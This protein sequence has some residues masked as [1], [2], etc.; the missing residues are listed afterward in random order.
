MWA[1]SR[2]GTVPPKTEELLRGLKMEKGQ[3]SKELRPPL[4]AK[5]RE[6]PGGPSPAD[7]TILAPGGSWR[8]SSLQNHGEYTCVLLT[9]CVLAI[10]HSSS[11]KPIHLCQTA[12]QPSATT[13]KMLLC[14]S[15]FRSLPVQDANGPERQASR[16]TQARGQAVPGCSQTRVPTGAHGGRVAGWQPAVL[17]ARPAPR[18]SPPR[19]ERRGELGPPQVGRLPGC[20]GLQ[21]VPVD[22]AGPE[23]LPADPPGPPSVLHRDQPSIPPRTPPFSPQSRP[24]SAP[25]L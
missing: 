21:D 14:C 17:C 6:C 3:W 13:E 25:C 2:R 16:G 7:S 22:C 11:K 23:A 19:T 10:R 12:G 18:Y 5:R 20:P 9:R 8:I 4:E 24:Q 15:N 1:K